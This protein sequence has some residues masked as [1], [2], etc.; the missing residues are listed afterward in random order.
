MQPQQT[1]LVPEMSDP[2]AV[3]YSGTHGMLEASM[4]NLKR[5]QRVERWLNP[6][7][8]RLGGMRSGKGNWEGVAVH[9]AH[10]HTCLV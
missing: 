9:P 5:V 3:Q 7:D 4:G 10:Q 2:W 6:K 1:S 8:I